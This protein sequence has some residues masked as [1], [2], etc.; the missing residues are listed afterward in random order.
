[1]LK[2]NSGI[3][4][5]EFCL[6]IVGKI[7]SCM[8]SL[9]TAGLVFHLPLTHKGILKFSLGN[10]EPLQLGAFDEPPHLGGTVHLLTQGVH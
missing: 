2:I 5:T 8:W 4:G 7:S 10:I 9:G 3:S 6:F 1:M